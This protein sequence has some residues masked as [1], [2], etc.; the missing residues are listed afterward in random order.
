MIVLLQ[1]VSRASV[2]IN[3]DVVGSIGNGLAVLVGIANGDTE[4]DVD[5]LAE[6]TLNLRIF[7]DND[8][9]FNLSILET[10]GELLIISQFT[11][12]ADAVKGR[13]P[14]FARAA[15]PDIAETLIKRYITEIR[16]SGLVVAS[17]R[18]QHPMMVEIHNDGP[19]TII[20]DSRDKYPEVR[21]INR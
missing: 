16:A 7:E 17:G 9:K 6:K 15:P 21:T 2:R 1:R 12:L 13:R 18:F 8:G 19:V 14:G 4:R 3:N 11:L 10:K 5:Y 20:L